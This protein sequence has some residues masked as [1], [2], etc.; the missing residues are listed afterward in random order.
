MSRWREI[1]ARLGWRNPTGGDKRPTE[2][3]LDAF[4]AAAGF[5]LPLD[6]RQ[7]ARACG[8]GWF[9]VSHEIEIHAPGDPASHNDLLAVKAFMAGFFSDENYAKG[10]GCDPVKFRRLVVFSGVKDVAEQFVWDPGE[11]TDP[12]EHEMAIYLLGGDLRPGLYRVASSFGE[13]VIDYVLSGRYGRECHFNYQKDY[14][15]WRTG[16]K[17]IEF[18]HVPSADPPTPRKRKTK[19]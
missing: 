6:Y 2:A 12:A 16:K 7:F 4:E 18:Y 13:F 3:D 19:K 8:H 17:K 5:K 1:K 10:H 9:A 11:V 15:A 14:D